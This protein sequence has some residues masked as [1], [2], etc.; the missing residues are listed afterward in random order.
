M[1]EE[2]ILTH[3]STLLRPGGATTLRRD[4]DQGGSHDSTSPYPT[5][6][7][8][9][10][11]ESCDSPDPPPTCDVEQGCHY[12]FYLFIPTLISM[13]LEIYFV[14]AEFQK[15]FKLHKWECSTYTK[16]LHLFTNN[17]K[18]ITYTKIDQKVFRWASN[19]VFTLET[20]EG[21]PAFLPLLPYLYG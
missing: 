10:K 18:N 20:D 17:K 16:T 1:A 12:S 3:S 9:G 4:Y 13:Y 19:Y 2:S 7:G 8:Q 5:R 6:V 21:C 14:A 11:R 15:I